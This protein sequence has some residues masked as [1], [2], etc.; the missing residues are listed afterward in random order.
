MNQVVTVCF[1][2]PPDVDSDLSCDPPQGLHGEE[3]AGQRAVRDLPDHLRGGQGGLQRGDRPP[4]AQRHP[5]GPGAQPGAAG[6]V[7]R[8]VDEGQ[9]LDA[10]LWPGRGPPA[11]L[12][13]PYYDKEKKS[14]VTG[15]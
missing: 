15:L 2:L 6:S 11:G 5:R 13:Q 4:A 1:P 14:P 7:D 3:A 8:A 10:P 12:S 9:Q